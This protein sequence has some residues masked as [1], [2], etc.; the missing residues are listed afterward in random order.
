VYDNEILTI[1]DQEFIFQTIQSIPLELLAELGSDD[2][3]LSSQRI[4]TGSLMLLS[5]LLK[6]SKVDGKVVIELGCGSGVCSIGLSKLSSPSKILAT[7]GDERS[8]DF[9]KGNID[10]N[11]CEGA[12][13]WVYHRWGEGGLEGEEGDGLIVVAGDVLY[14][15]SLLSPFFSSLST[16]LSS[17][18]TTN[19]GIVS[20]VPRYGVEVAHVVEEGERVGLTSELIHFEQEEHHEFVRRYC[21]SDEVERA[22][23][24]QFS[25]NQL[26]DK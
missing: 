17:S 25:I 3:E 22:Q 13:E 12:I 4:W 16:L 11:G 23:I 15:Q 9:L 2:D 19:I 1:C 18:P 24:I 10:R 14:K 6:A 26:I 20:H 5:Y 8:L 21:P 7:D